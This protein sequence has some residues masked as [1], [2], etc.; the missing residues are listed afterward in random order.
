MNHS[1]RPRLRLPRWTAQP[2][3]GVLAL[4]VLAIALIWH[5]E[6]QP[7]SRPSGTSVGVSGTASAGAAVPPL[8]VLRGERLEAVQ[9][10]KVRPVALPAAAEPRSV[11]TNRGLS[12]V[13]A[14]VGSRQ[15]AY[16]VTARLRVSDLG[17]ADAVLPAVRGPAAVIVESALVDPGTLPAPSDQPTPSASV[18]ASTSARPPGEPPLR[19]FAI[20]RYGTDGRPLELPDRLPRGFRL[21]TDTDVGLV[22]WQPVNRIFDN[23]AERESLSAAA[24]LIRPDDTLRPLGPVH[25]LAADSRDLL[26]WDVALRRFGIMPLHYATSTATSTDS[27]TGSPS[28]KPSSTARATA[29][30]GSPSPEPT[31]VAGTRWFL[32]TRGMLLVTGPAAFSA[33]GSAFA[34]Y[35]QV[36]SRRRLVVAQLKDLGTDQVEVLVLTQPPVHSSP[37]P[38][39]SPSGT[40]LPHGTTTPASVSASQTSSSPEPTASS[41]ALAP[42]GYPLPAPLVPLWWAGM[43]IGV[44]PDG[45]VI[46][47]RLGDPLST[48]LD[49]GLSQVRALAALP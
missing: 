20:R 4:L 18:T 47:Y 38:S 43:V 35:A 30:T 5:G 40:V 17:Y 12:V 19:D 15:R 28:E 11:I 16:A 29:A 48:Q 32:P 2:G 7:S 27:P 3:F 34:V 25:P 42:D 23:G 8:L 13:L 36:G 41:P 45:T 33:D 49:L 44:A 37:A 9:Q 39:G 14:V 10:G 21:G 1:R 6:P 31:V 46:S 22:V 24:L 26:V